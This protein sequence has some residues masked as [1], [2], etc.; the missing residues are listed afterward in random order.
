MPERL[1]KV[2]ATSFPQWS[3]RLACT[4]HRSGIRQGLSR[5]ATAPMKSSSRVAGTATSRQRRNYATLSATFTPVDNMLTRFGNTELVSDDL[6]A[7]A[8]N[9]SLGV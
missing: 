8:P 6:I 5:N 4:R 9:F 3:R 7:P 2:A 1:V